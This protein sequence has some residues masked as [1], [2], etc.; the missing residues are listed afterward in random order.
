LKR[1]LPVLIGESAP[2]N[3]G[4]PSSHAVNRTT[5]LPGAPCLLGV[6]RIDEVL[7]V[8]LGGRSLLDLPIVAFEVP[9]NGIGDLVL[10]LLV[11]DSAH[12]A[13]TTK[14]VAQAHDNGKAEIVSTRP[15]AGIVRTD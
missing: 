10:F 6:R 15:H 1:I 3:T 14:P 12:A 7:P 11:R 9:H 4:N 5:E 2:E 13:N 8:P